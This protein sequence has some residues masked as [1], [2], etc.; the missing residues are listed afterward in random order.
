MAVDPDGKFIHNGP[1]KR[2]KIPYMAVGN[3]PRG[4]MRVS[5]WVAVVC[6]ATRR[7]LLAKR[8]PTTRNAGQWNFFG[9][10]VDPGE[11]PLKTAVRELKEEGGIVVNR[12][13]LMVLGEAATPAKHNIL[14]ALLL[15]D[16][17]APILNGESTHWEWVGITDLRHRTDLHASTALLLDCLFRWASQLPRRQMSEFAID[18]DD[19]AADITSP[20]CPEWNGLKI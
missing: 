1:M 16:E 6:S 8:A 5:V 11:R 4:R 12:E 14:F 10:G 19:D 20:H 17:F 9:G 7:V 3:G 2:K 18:T 13:E 15:D